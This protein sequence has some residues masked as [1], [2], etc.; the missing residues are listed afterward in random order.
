MVNEVIEPCF[1]FLINLRTRMAREVM[2]VNVPTVRR[3]GE[4]SLCILAGSRMALC[5]SLIVFSSLSS[6]SP[7]SNHTIGTKASVA[8]AS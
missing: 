2:M 5:N 3:T 7:S 8:L 4:S 1:L 6:S